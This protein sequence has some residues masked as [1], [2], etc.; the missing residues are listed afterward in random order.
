MSSCAASYCICSPRASFV[1]VTSAS[2]PTADA[3]RYCRYAW[4]H[5]AQFLRRSNQKPPP[6]S[7]RN[8]FGVAPSVAD[9]W[10]SSND[11]PLLKSNFVLHHPCSLLQ[12]ETAC[13]NS[14]T[15]H[16]SPR[17][18]PVRPAP[19][20][21]PTSPSPSP[22]FSPSILAPTRSRTSSSASVPTPANFKTSSL[23]HSICIRP[24]S[25]AR[26]FATA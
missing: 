15:L 3:P 17:S 1:S 22:P 6:L 12:H 25:P 23:L 14:K 13:P 20:P 18:A 4:Q 7:N 19:D 24:A 11:L 8:L 16:G 10:R 5:W 9:R 21:I 2:L 26:H